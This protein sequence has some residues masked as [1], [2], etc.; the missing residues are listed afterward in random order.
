MR[1]AA[2]GE[3]DISRPARRGTGGRRVNCDLFDQVVPH[4]PFILAE[5]GTQ[6]LTALSTWPLGPP[7]SL[8]LRRAKARRVRRSPKGEDG[9]LSRG[10]T[11]RHPTIRL[12][13]LRDAPEIA[14]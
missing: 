14:F 7:P 1:R 11:E 9:P 8:K 3:R 2:C 12:Y 13:C 5:A 10:R 6:T 4:S